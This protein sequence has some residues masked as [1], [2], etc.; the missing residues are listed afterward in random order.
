[1]DPVL[2]DRVLSAVREGGGDV[3]TDPLASS[4]GYP[5]KVVQV[6]GSVSNPE[7]YAARPRVCDNGYLRE[8][9]A[10]GGSV[11]YRCAAEPVAAYLAKGGAVEDT[12]ERRC[13]CNGLLATAGFPQVQRDGTVEPPIITSGDDL[14]RLATLLP[15]GRDDYGADDVIRYLT[16]AAASL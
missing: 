3:R 14:A 6:E 10:E 9:V 15:A 16:G 1:M 11:T 12:A 2:R 13:L 8:P 5:F 4:S 7:V